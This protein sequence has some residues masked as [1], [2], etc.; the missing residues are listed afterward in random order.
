[1]RARVATIAPAT[2]EHETAPPSAGL[3]LETPADLRRLQRAIGNSGVRTLLA[4]GR[5]AVARYRL[6][7]DAVM[8][9]VER[10]PFMKG[11]LAGAKVRGE[12]M[13][14][15]VKRQVDAYN[16]M[17]AGEH[18]GRTN[19]A[20]MLA[21]ALNGVARVIAE[22]LYDPGI[23]AKLAGHLF[24]LYQHEIT[25]ETG[26]GAEGDKR[27]TDSLA[28]TKVLLSDDP[29]GLYMHN[30][31]R[32]EVAAQRIA[33][34][35]KAMGRKPAAMFELLRHKWEAEMSAYTRSGLAQAEPKGAYN[36]KESTGELSGAYFE[37]LFGKAAAPQRKS[38]GGLV[39][40][41]EAEDRLAALLNEVT[42]PSAPVDESAFT[43][44]HAGMTKKQERHL[45]EIE[46]GEKPAVIDGA[47]DQLAALIA[48][49]LG[50]ARAEAD[51]LTRTIEAWLKTVPLTITVEGERWFAKGGPRD[52]A[53]KFKPATETAKKTAQ[54]AD[55]FEKPG[56]AGAIDY[57]GKYEDAK[58]AAE[59]GDKY[60]RF[61][62]WK[63]DLMTGLLGMGA[64]EMPAFGAARSSIRTRRA[65]WPPGPGS[66]TTATFTSC[67]TRTC[68]TGS[69]TPRP[70]T[71][72][73]AGSR[74]W[75]CS[76]S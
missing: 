70:I 47:R 52:D 6:S 25:S 57:A 59:R 11:K 39:L 8:S 55:V 10:I 60:L 76:T 73:R 17:F 21:T 22:E 24:D 53:A 14:A 69:S 42:T 48:E 62:R 30:E 67:S 40:A 15:Q 1:V 71:G 4:P 32:V 74:C 41:K 37:K 61:R 26:L 58:H 50:L 23:Q 43:P 68:A 19:T 54:L 28:M 38:S 63:D 12:A 65:G 2:P 34:M 27:G 9:A 5:R 75:R 64:S 18:R 29:L 51:A 16:A 49:A 56:A 36:V 20:V 72:R 66:A 31:L 44:R 3:R 45:S 35:A 13:S 7:P 33:T 46:Q